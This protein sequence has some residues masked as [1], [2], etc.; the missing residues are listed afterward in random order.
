MYA[1]NTRHEKMGYWVSSLRCEFHLPNLITV[2]RFA[3]STDFL[4]H[5]DIFSQ[6]AHEK[7]Y[8]LVM[9]NV[10]WCTSYNSWNVLWANC[11]LWYSSHK[12]SSGHRS[13]PWLLSTLFPNLMLWFLTGSSKNDPEHNELLRDTDD[14]KIMFYFCVAFYLF[15]N[16]AHWLIHMYFM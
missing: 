7:P 8:K 9:E 14:S 11:Y 5:C 16:H 10:I 2:L 3:S 6:Y 15:S 12:Y 4:S 13:V 1:I